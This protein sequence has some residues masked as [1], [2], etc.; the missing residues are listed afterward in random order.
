MFTLLLEWVGST[1]SEAHQA[2]DRVLN[3]DDLAGRKHSRRPALYDAI[4]CER[5]A[6]GTVSSLAVAGTSPLACKIFAVAQ[7]TH[8]KEKP[9]LPTERINTCRVTDAQVFW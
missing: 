2:L 1:K 4:M 3:E 9:W 8:V 6:C 5:Q 7:P